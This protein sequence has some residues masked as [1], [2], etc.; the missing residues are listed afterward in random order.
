MFGG[1]SR[2]LDKKSFA[3]K[4]NSSTGGKLHYKVF[5]N[6]DLVEFNTLVLRSGSQDQTSSMIRDEF[7]S[8]MLINYGTLDAQAAKPVVLYINGKYWGVYFLREKINTDFIEN[9]YNA[10][11]SITIPEVLRPYMGGKDKIIPKK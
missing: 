4:F 5:D 1:Q 10:D 2:E 11:G 7:N 8:T 9:N 6:K 3:L